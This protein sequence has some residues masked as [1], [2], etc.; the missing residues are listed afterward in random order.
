MLCARAVTVTHS[1][2]GSRGGVDRPKVG[3]MERQAVLVSS[4]QSVSPLRSPGSGR[5][6]RRLGSSAPSAACQLFPS[7]TQSLVP[8]QRASGSWAHLA[9][10][11]GSS[12]SRGLVPRRERAPLKRIR[13]VCA[14]AASASEQEGA[15]EVRNLRAIGEAI[16]GQLNGRSRLLQG[17]PYK[18]LSYIYGAVSLVPMVRKVTAC[19]LNFRAGTAA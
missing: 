17:L 12:R 2:P 9:S 16:S 13:T 5:Q 10:T 14:A 3:E 11:P 7:Q 4:G 8:G 19:L 6:Q 18:V 1:P 15:S